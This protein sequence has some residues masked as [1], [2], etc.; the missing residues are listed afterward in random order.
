MSMSNY[1]LPN[2][3]AQTKMY[4]D[5]CAQGELRYQRCASCGHV[6]L[7]ARSLCEQCQS[8]QLEWN[9]S[10]RKGTVL[11]FTTV[12]R[13]PLPVFKEMLPYVI[14]IV[15]MDEG[16]RVMANALPQVQQGPLAIGARVQIG[17]T[18][19]HGMALPV[20][21]QLLEAGQ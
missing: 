13:A 4:W 9:T 3:N 11:T 14:A 7:F 15:D 2:P 20:L 18:D 1:P 16:F 17:F 19:V 5:G 8:T 21:Q 12:Y 6:Q 10:A